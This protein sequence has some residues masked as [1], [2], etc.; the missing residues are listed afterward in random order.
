MK[1]IESTLQSGPRQRGFGL[2]EVMVGLVIG[3][4]AVLVIY[5]VFNVAEAFK[6]NTTAAGEA[7]STGLFSTFL[8]GM[9]LANGGTAMADSA[10]YLAVCPD[11]PGDPM[12]LRFA[13]SFRPIP[14]VITDGGVNSDSFVVNY[15]IASTRVTPATFNYKDIAGAVTTYS[16]GDPYNIQSPDGF[17]VGDLVVGINPNIPDCRSS[18]ITAVSAPDTQL[19]NLYGTLTDVANVTITHTGTPI[20]FEGDGRPGLSTLFNMG[21]AD[22]AQKIRYS[23]NNCVNHTTFQSCTLY[24]TPLLDSNGCPF[25][26]AG[27]PATAV[28]NPLASNIV[29]MRV[30]YGIANAGDP[31][32]LLAT[33][34][35][36]NVGGGWDPATLLP[37]TVP[38]INQIKAIRIGIIVQSEQFDK[39][40]GG[41]TGGDYVNGNYNWVLFDCADA[42][43]ANCPGRLTGSVPATISPAGN[44][45]FRKYETVIPLR[46]E[47]WNKT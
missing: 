19:I 42:N 46:N 2:V 11:Y 25:G 24:S 20:G 7:Q 38:T 30:E 6:R 27:C 18:K 16:A 13:K 43:K 10:T 21:P 29:L 17:H 8:L 40:L 39:S 1:T 41:Y 14:V 23:L 9:E 22:R 3:L 15:S 44:W 4:I 32:A 36:A 35:Q 47:I 28:D 26:A 5:Q 37:A 33:W 31:Q 12:P 34:V 45:R